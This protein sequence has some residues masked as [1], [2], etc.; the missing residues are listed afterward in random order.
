MLRWKG[1]MNETVMVFSITP[2]E[3]HK[4]PFR[5]WNL[6]IEFGLVHVIFYITERHD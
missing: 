6:I 1:E 4:A 2:S 5:L 3:L